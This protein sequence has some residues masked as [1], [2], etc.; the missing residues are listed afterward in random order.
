M[1]EGCNIKEGRCFWRSA[2]L[3]ELAEEQGIMPV[4][5]IDKIAECWPSDDDPDALLAFV[6]CERTERLKITRDEDA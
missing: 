3:E 2:S 4:T 1:K 6:L 5:D